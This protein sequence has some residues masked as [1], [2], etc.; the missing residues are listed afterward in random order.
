MKKHIVLIGLFTCAVL[1]FPTMANAQSL[2]SASTAYQTFVRLN[3]ENG[4]KATMYSALYQCYRD[5]AAVLNASTPGSM[6]YNQAKSALKDIFPYLQ[7]GAVFYSQR[8]D[9]KNALLFAQAYVDIPLIKAFKG[10]VLPKDSY[11]PTM[12]YFAASGTYNSKDYAKA[13]SY[14]REYLDT[15]D[16]KKRQSVFVF[17]AKACGHIGDHALARSVLDEAISNY[18]ADFNM[19]ST[20]IN[21]CIDTKDNEGLQK[22]VDKAMLIKPNDPTLL[23]IQGK[24]YE[25]TNDYLKALHIYTK[26]RSS[27]PRS[28]EVAK[29][30][31][32]N[33]YNLG[34]VCYNKGAMEGKTKEGT[35]LTNKSKEYFTAAATVFKDVLAADPTSLKY[36]QALATAYNCLGNERE[37]T[38]L[39]SKIASLGGNT[40][41]SSTVPALVNYAGTPATGTPAPSYT[42]SAIEAG[43]YSGTGNTLASTVTASTAPTYSQ[44]AKDYVEKKISTWQMKDPYETV[45]EYKQRVTETTR[46]AK[47]KELLK[48]AESSY[49]STYAQSL[50]VSEMELKPYDA[51]NQVFLVQSK[52][53]E[54]ILPVPRENNEAK[55]FA[56]NWNG[57]Q[58]KEPKFYI[59]NDRLAL[60]SLTF[61]T[62]MGNSYCYNDKEALNYTETSVDVR[63]DAIDYG[64]LAQSGA[65]TTPGSRIQKSQ[66]KVGSSDVDLNIPETKASNDKCFAV[67]ISN[68]NYNMVS[69]VPMAL[70]DG[71]T[72]RRYCQ[73][74]L[75]IPQNNIRFYPDASYGTMLRAMRD[76]KDIA[77]AYTGDIRVVFYYAGHGIPNEATKDAFLLP[78]DA[79]GTQTE[80]CYSLNKLYTELGGLNAQSVVVFLDACFS[81][82]KRDGGM[83]ASARGVALKAKKEAPKGNMVIFS[84]ASDDETAF[85]Y[86][87]KGHGLFTYFLLKKLQETQGDV[88]LQ[89]LGKYIT[90]NVKQQSVVVNRKVQTPTVSPST[91]LSDN[92]QK[93]KLKP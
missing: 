77:S 44:Y 73:K 87:D 38:A 20:A 35:E 13:I 81:G 65:A 83:L 86:K 42:A 74:T 45:D 76:I 16:T 64:A 49:I 30:L 31:G 57:I 84:A 3:N 59:N 9:Q 29:H 25:E 6:P 41:S 5:Y 62:P 52:Y 37:L 18:P 58:L 19:L 27:N 75:G 8:N 69:K 89:E 56:S 2:E 10:E 90:E 66:I 21:C 24:L 55:I 4:D 7:K 51:D 68:E 93:L 61:V 46:N 80:G 92:W 23:N 50:L 78:I 67:I 34:V 22:Y 91:S 36:M 85:P 82:A 47:V 71:E 39:N 12:V 14:F 15:H 33:Y 88:T 32:L 60:S 63:F 54:I 53:G 11:Y 1:F 79:D 28:L 70:N 40:V 48:E 72:F 17:M 43:A 26:L